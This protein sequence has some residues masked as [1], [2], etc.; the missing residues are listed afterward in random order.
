MAL[1]EYTIILVL[2][3]WILDVHTHT[4][5][6][7]ERSKKI[8]SEGVEER[9]LLRIYSNERHLFAAKRKS[10]LYCEIKRILR[11]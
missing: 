4:H 6:H 1:I 5:T 10:S 9:A 11:P 3:Y 2:L 8:R 7:T